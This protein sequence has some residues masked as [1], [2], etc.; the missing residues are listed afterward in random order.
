[1]TAFDNAVENSVQQYTELLNKIDSLMTETRSKLQSATPDEHKQIL[2]RVDDL[3][4]IR[5]QL[6]DDVKAQGISRDVLERTERLL[7]IF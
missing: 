7:S 2:E 4:T 3:D 6:V 5:Q 1:M